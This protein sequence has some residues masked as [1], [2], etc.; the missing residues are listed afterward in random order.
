[1]AGIG[2][3]LRKLSQRDDFA[4]TLMAYFYS[5]MISSGPW[6]FTVL[7]LGILVLVGNQFLDSR[8]ITEFR[9]III[10]NFSFSLIL[11]A[12][13]FMVATRYLADMIYAH[14]VSGAPGLLVGMFA[15]V[16]GL[17]GPIAIAFYF[18]YAQMESWVQIFSV[19]NYLLISGIWVATVFISALKEFAAITRSFGIGMLIALLASIL[20]SNAF[21][22]AG[23]LTGFNLGLMFILFDLIARIL[24]EYPG[25]PRKYFA[26]LRYFR[27]HWELALFGLFYNLAVWVD[28]WIMWSSSGRTIQNNGLVSYPLYD[29]AMFLAYLSFVPAIALFTFS[30]ETR[31]YEQYLRFFQD[32]QNHA[33]YDLIKRNAQLLWKTILDSAQSILILQLTIAIGL[34]LIA[35]FLLSLLQ[36]SPLQLGIFRYGVLGGVFHVF[37]MF[38]IT[39]LSYF[40]VRKK[41]LAIAIIFFLSNVFFTAVSIKMGIQWYG[42]GYTIASIISFAVAYSLVAGHIARLPYETFV[43]RNA[44]I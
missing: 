6:L 3:V 32:I 23:L 26:F 40:D 16:Y 25:V 44:S 29:G 5:A 1:M 22:V 38:L 36:A 43:V 41:V 42:W 39:V 35:P 20:L 24:S 10:Y 12:P 17:T 19:L 13:V 34:I 18:F 15:F 14:D 37:T 7:C 28:K 31:F 4:R 33:T 11:S 9:I 21:G 8:D 30:V 2:F 27:T